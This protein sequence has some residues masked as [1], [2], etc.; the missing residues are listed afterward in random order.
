MPAFLIAYCVNIDCSYAE[1]CFKAG[2]DEKVFEDFRRQDPYMCVVET[3][4]YGNGL[5]FCARN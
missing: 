2:K 3:L 4:G 5:V 1:F